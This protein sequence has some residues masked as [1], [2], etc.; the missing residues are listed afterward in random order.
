MVL[1]SQPASQPASQPSSSM[2]SELIAGRRRLP[3]CRCRVAERCATGRERGSRA[4]APAVA[5]A[6]AAALVLPVLVAPAVAHPGHITNQAPIA[7]AATSPEGTIVCSVRAATNSSRQ[8]SPAAIQVST[9][10]ADL[11]ATATTWPSNCGQST[12]SVPVFHDRD[13]DT[14]TY[15]LD[16]TL[17]ANV[18]TLALGNTV[19]PRVTT[20]G[21]FARLWMRGVALYRAAD[22][23]ITITAADPHGGSVSHVHIF[24]MGGF[25]GT[26]APTLGTVGDQQLKPHEA[27]T[28]L[29]LPAATGGDVTLSGT[30]FP[31][32][33]EVG[34]LPPGLRFDPATR[35]ISGT[36]VESGTYTVTY[37]A[38]DA[39]TKS[40]SLN[41][42]AK[43]ATDTA[44]RTF[45]ITVSGTATTPTID[46]VRIVSH[47]THDADSNGQTDT[48]VFRDEILVDVE[49]SEPIEVTGDYD[50]VRLRLDL[51]ADDSNKDNSRVTATLQSVLYG[52]RT[53]RFAYTVTSTD[54]DADGVWVQPGGSDQVVFL[55]GT[56]KA[57][58]KSADSG[59]DANLTKSGLPTTGNARAKVDGTVTTVAGPIPQSATVSGDTLTVTFNEALRVTNT[60]H[61]IWNLEVQLSSVHGGNRNAQ[62]YPTAVSVSGSTLTLTL[63]PPA[64]AGDRVTLTYV[65]NGSNKPLEDTSGNVAP[66]FRDLA[67]TNVT[68]GPAPVRGLVAGKTLTMEFDG[69]LD[70]A[71]APSGGAFLVVATDRD[72]DERRI[73]GT[74]TAAVAGSS[75]TVTLLHAVDRNELVSVTYEPPDTSPLQGA[76][77]GNPRVP[78]FDHFRVEAVH[79][80]TPPTFQS[81]TLASTGTSQSKFFLWYDEPLDESSVPQYGA[82]ADGGDIRVSTGTLVPAS[83]ATVAVEGRAVIVTVE[84]AHAAG[85]NAVAYAHVTNPIRDLAGNPAADFSSQFIAGN[86]AQSGKPG[87]ERVFVDGALLRVAF[88][89]ND[90]LDPGSVPASSAFTFSEDFIRIADVEVSGRS[91]RLNLESPVYPCAPSFTLTYTVPS[92]SP[93]QGLDG[94]D[95]DS[96][97][98][99]AVTNHRASKCVRHQVSGMGGPSG[100]GGPSWKS[101][102]LNFDRTLDTGKTLKAE[103]FGLSGASGASAPSVEGASFT[104]DAKG[105]VL[106]L[107]RALASGEQVTASY[108]RPARTVGL[109]DGAGN[110]IA[111]FSGV[112][113]TNDAPDPPADLPALSVSDARAVEGEAIE[114]TVSLSAASGEAVTV[115]YATSDGTAESGTDYTAASG[116]LI[117]AAGATSETVRVETAD[118]SEDEDDETFTLTLSNPSGATLDDAEATGAIEDDDEPAALTASFENLPAGHDGKKLFAFEIVFS[119]EFEGLKLTAFEAGAL[120]VTGG[121]LVDAKRVTRGENRRVA[122]RVRPSSD[123]D[124]T[125]TLAATTD[126]AAA[127]AICAADGRKL[128]SPVSA[129]VFGPGNA[130][131]TGAP[132]ISGETRAGETLTATTDGIADPDGLSGATFSF[133]WVRSADGSDTDISGATGS[134]YTLTD[135]DVGATIKVRARFTDDAGNSEALTSAATAVVAPRP[136]SPATG[137]PAISG[138]AQAGETLTASTEGISDADGLSGAAFSFQWV[139][140]ADGSDTDISGA[141]GSSYALADADVGATIKVRASFTDDAGNDEELTSAA[142]A[143]VEPRPLTAEFD[144]MPAEHDGVR[145]FSFELVFSENFPGRFPHTTLRDSA[146]TVTN[147][148]VRSAERVVKGENRRWR[149]GVRPSSNDDLTI[150]LAAGAVST[151]S[152]RPLSNTVSATVAGPVGVSVADARVEEGAGAVLA[153]AVTLSRAATSAFSVDYA[154]S[155]GT[156]Q[157]GADYT[158]ASGTLSF[159]AGDSSKTIEV[160]VLD[161][162]HDEGEET[163]TL[164]LSNASGAWLSDGEATGTI[165]NADLMPAALLARFSRA[166]AEQVVTTIEERMAAPRQRGFRARFA[167]RELRSGQERDFAL[168]FLTQFAQ[169]M[170]MGPAGAAAMGGAAPMGMGSHAPGA[171]TGGTGMPGMGVPGT[172]GSMGMRGS[173]G[174]GGSIGM[175]GAGM[176]G[177]GGVSGMGGMPGAMGT[178]GRH[179]PMGGA[180]AGGG[181]GPADTA[182]GGGLF[183]S[184]GVGGDLFS[185]SEFE[186][187]RESRGGILSVW[188]R[189][190]RSHFTGMED[191]LSL[192]GD[193]RTTT[194]GADWARGPL[195]LGLSVGRTLGMGG[196]SGPSGGQMTTSMTGVYPWVGYQVN[197][198]VSVWG[199]TG[200][201]TGSLSLTPDGQSALETGVSM[202]MSAVG[203][204]GELVGSRATGGFALAFKTDALWVGAASDL[205]DGPTGRLNASE[206]GVT[207]VRTALEGSRGFTLGGDRLSLTP[208]VEVGLR[209]DGGDAETGAGMDVGGGLAFADTVTG[210]SLDVRVRTLVVHQAEGFSD[211]GMSLSFGWDPTPSSP[212]GLT[213]RVAPS[214]GGSAQGGAEALWSNQMAYGM[215]SHQMYGAGGQVNAEVGYGLPVGV[216]FVG[217]PRVGLTSS[218]YGRD[219]RVGYGL[220]VLEQGKLNFEVGVDAQRRESPMHGEA[221]NGVLGR[222]TI[223]W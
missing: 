184:M 131:A 150:T 123:E 85:S 134:S 124:M 56:P 217:T 188:S 147:G 172:A 200:Y 102:T 98:N 114:F 164:T 168:G 156:A 46:L 12:G 107:N 198:R 186:L 115:D 215:G 170:G 80:V 11:P 37:T 70:P 77:S 104:D 159:Q 183:D 84:R 83:A 23:D 199:T 192:N 9:V 67:V 101:V 31:Y 126:C 178:A 173:T 6:L 97:T 145:L 140:S 175:G 69:T 128:S 161:D 36:P 149:I 202:M 20:A 8:T 66:A 45:T 109:W 18:R 121:R 209:R 181:Y 222:A 4:V 155:D 203:T 137:A 62:Q 171:A 35:T 100:N 119:E 213:A 143:A 65:Y 194:V 111:D 79:D 103:A 205:L 197:D 54:T 185:N 195:T 71:S 26:S 41:P 72:D 191:A 148:S 51:G 68:G 29:V 47:P 89:A 112:R 219:Y 24:E 15:T 30:T 2:T 95:A 130:A 196:Y 64:Q 63:D 138:T 52:G 78:S 53:L 208:S 154:T 81:L 136:N 216:R 214:W 146:F 212:L 108:T 176:P 151:E 50:N 75:V 165:E 204:R 49:Y 116:T 7:V 189:S 16:Y 34:G 221:G 120:E 5:A 135:S 180:A 158:A 142:T 44:T 55:A 105:V 43:D 27:M 187:N 125:L 110:Q 10:L 223:G 106:A 32:L 94:T 60:S 129:T 1:P 220:G 141:T 122:V 76:G 14:L 163:L 179:A 118:D 21:T 153:F 144:G 152:G 42:A 113:V 96:I 40:A 193:V 90:N 82:A 61:L 3:A 25:I 17:P 139:R 201:G 174:V 58:L 169:P 177:M 92:T 39:D 88:G 133:Q 99:Q 167:G 218:P 28:D 132:A 160:A 157:A 38:D 182:H 166:T 127:S 91:V 190:S 93:I 117:F 210:L 86:D 22:L 57:T 73:R 74:G 19:F 48:Y 207:R 162:A 33:Y 59:T 13:G 87:L 206:A 211:R